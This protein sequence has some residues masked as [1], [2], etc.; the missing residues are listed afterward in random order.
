MHPWGTPLQKG[1]AAWDSKYW[2][3]HSG[4]VKPQPWHFTPV[5]LSDHICE[6]G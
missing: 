5:S 6:M 3:C 2:P 4:P 1:E